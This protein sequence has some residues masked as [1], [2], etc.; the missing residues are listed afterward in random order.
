MPLKNG[1]LVISLRGKSS[2]F[3]ASLVAALIA[4]VARSLAWN[5]APPEDDEY[6]RAFTPPHSVSA[7][8]SRQAA[9]PSAKACQSA[10][11]NAK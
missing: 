6:G 3:I 8:V 4:R 2:C 9:Q 1:A 11:L 5:F 7:F 10:P